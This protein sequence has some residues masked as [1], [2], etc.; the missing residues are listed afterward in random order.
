MLSN[1]PSSDRDGCP[2]TSGIKHLY[3]CCYCFIV[4]LCL[5]L[6]AMAQEAPWWEFHAAYQFTA[7]QTGQVQD[8]VTAISQPASL[9]NVSVGNHLNMNGWDLS[10]QENKNHWFGGII[11]FSGGYATRNVTLSGAGATKVTANFSPALFTM[12]GG[13]QFT[14]RRSDRIQP[15]ARV[16][17]AA[18]YSNLNPSKSVS[19]ALSATAAS[20]NTSDI[21]LAILAGGGIDYRLKNYAF[22]RTAGDYVHTS[23][24][25]EATNNFR[26]T[27]GVT[28]R[29]GS[30]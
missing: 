9:P 2:S 8:V 27:A 28:L 24:F 12:G 10:V 22:L 23:G 17:C 20:L 16:I 15:F 25:G 21:G 29:L 5:C 18:A 14:Y 3:Y 4:T 13:P 1:A 7:Y 19:D 11:D 30:K 26:V 6:N